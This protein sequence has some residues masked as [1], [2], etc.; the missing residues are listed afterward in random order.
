MRV[1][2]AGIMVLVA[3]AVNPAARLFRSHEHYHC[4]NYRK[5]YRFFDN[6]CCILEKT[7][8]DCLQNHQKF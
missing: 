5:L 7:A 3:I 2:R 6:L 8:T 4:C 1:A